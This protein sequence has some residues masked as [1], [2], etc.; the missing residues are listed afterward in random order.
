MRWREQPWFAF[1]VGIGASV[2]LYDIHEHIFDRG[3]A[4]VIGAVSLGSII[5]ILNSRA[6]AS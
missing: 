1:G 4:Y 6:R 5:A 3:G 2:A